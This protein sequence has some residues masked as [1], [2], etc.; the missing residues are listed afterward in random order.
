MSAQPEITVPTYTTMPTGVGEV[1]ITKYRPPSDKLPVRLFGTDLTFALIH[2]A[3]EADGPPDWMHE[4]PGSEG[5]WESVHTL[6]LVMDPDWGVLVVEYPFTAPELDVARQVDEAVG[7]AREKCRML[8]DLLP[9]DLAREADA[10]SLPLGPAAIYV[11]DEELPP[12]RRLASDPGVVVEAGDW[13]GIPADLREIAR[14]HAAQP[15]PS[16]G[17]A[18]G[19]LA[20][21]I[22]AL[23]G[24]VDA[25][26]EHAE[27]VQN[28]GI[29]T[30]QLFGEEI[31]AAEGDER[32]ER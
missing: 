28:L 1:E 22:E 6:N 30:P 14:H 3:V 11:G 23:D 10:G 15:D 5:H 16:P 25:Y 31:A 7:R 18:A 27:C 20:D 9:D 12:G 29:T 24:R 2:L 21:A 26:W 19:S 17:E 32:A 4:M 8:V 13:R